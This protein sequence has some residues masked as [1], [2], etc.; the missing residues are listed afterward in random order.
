MT[1]L[2]SNKP[3]DIKK[4]KEKKKN[5][6]NGIRPCWSSARVKHIQMEFSLS[7]LCKQRRLTAYPHQY[8][9]RNSQIQH[10][11]PG[12]ALYLS[13]EPLDICLW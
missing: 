1:R 6:D 5:V 3:E 13:I 4:W 10:Q 7:P 8:T 2:S 9:T 11:E 12:R